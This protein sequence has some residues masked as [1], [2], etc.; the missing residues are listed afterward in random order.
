MFYFFFL[1]LKEKIVK[2]SLAILHKICHSLILEGVIILYVMWL[3]HV[4]RVNLIAQNTL[5][6]ELSKY[7]Q[8]TIGN[9]NNFQVLQL[10]WIKLTVTSWNV[11]CLMW[12]CSSFTTTA[13]QAR[14]PETGVSCISLPSLYFSAYLVLFNQ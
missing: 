3:N 10:L 9:N 7:T 6:L 2:L 1:M 14:F 5:Y 12:C 8:L 13:D 4:K 11:F